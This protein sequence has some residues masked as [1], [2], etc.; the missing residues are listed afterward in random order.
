MQQTAHQKKTHTHKEKMGCQKMTRQ[1]NQALRRKIIAQR[2]SSANKLDDKDNE[3]RSTMQNKPWKSIKD[4]GQR[5]KLTM[6]I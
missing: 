3:R 6:K 1:E 4:Q 5:N 2:K